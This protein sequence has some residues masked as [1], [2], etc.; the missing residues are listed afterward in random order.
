MWARIGAF[1]FGATYVAGALSMI[2]AS[3]LLKNELKAMIPSPLIGFIVGF[4]AVMVVLCVA[5]W[6]LWYGSRLLKGSFR[7]SAIR[8]Q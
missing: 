4:F 5:C 3:F 6:L 2:A 7:H 8:R 1:V